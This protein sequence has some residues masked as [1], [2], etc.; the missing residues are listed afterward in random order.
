MEAK[1]GYPIQLSEGWSEM[2]EAIDYEIAE[3]RKK[4]PSAKNVHAALYEEIGEATKLLLNQYH[5]EAIPSRDIYR[6]LIQA[7]A[8]IVRLAQEGDP[9][10]F[11]KYNAPPGI[12]RQK[13]E[14]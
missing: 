7:A 5:S 12:T 1:M 9:L 14:G 2:A 4:F 6:E 11:P 8:M 3:A 10:T 13:I